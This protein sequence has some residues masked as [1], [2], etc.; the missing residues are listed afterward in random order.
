MNA[1][2]WGSDAD[3]LA[4]TSSHR[5]PAALH[6]LRDWATNHVRNRADVIVNLRPGYH[7]GSATFDRVVTMRS[8]HGSLDASQSLGFA[9]TTDGPLAGPARA[10]ELLPKEKRK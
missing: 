1:E 5:Y 7:Q 10:E 9:A 4:A 2:G 3:W 6:R 8:T